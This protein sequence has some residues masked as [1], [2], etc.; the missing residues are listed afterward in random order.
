MLLT[1]S[2]K[3][4][5]KKRKRKTEREEGSRE[6]G[7]KKGGREGRREKGREEKEQPLPSGSWSVL[8]VGPCYSLPGHK[9]FH[10]TPTSDKVPLGP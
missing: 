4:P 3:S 5:K 7:R 8:T 2:F 1:Q 10:G 9:K 6:R